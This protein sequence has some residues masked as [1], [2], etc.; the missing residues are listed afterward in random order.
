MNQFI[1]SKL[2]IGRYEF[3]VALAI[4]LCLLM[5]RLLPGFQTLTVCIAVLFCLQEGPRATWKSGIVRLGIT[6]IGG[7]IGF[8]VVLLDNRFHQPWLLFGLSV[9]GV[10]STLIGCKLLNAPPFSARIGGVTFLM[11]LYMRSGGERVYVPALRLI[12]TLYGILAVMLV[13]TLFSWIA[14]KRKAEQDHL[15]A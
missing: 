4:S 1:F 6:A 15:P 11:V 8:G 5:A 12:S 13:S 10:V 3:G 7:L 2:R 9:L 14:Q